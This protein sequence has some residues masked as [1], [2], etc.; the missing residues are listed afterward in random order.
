MDH[1]L[2]T[3][4][5]ERHVGGRSSDAERGAVEAHLEGCAECRQRVADEQLFA[6]VREFYQKPMADDVADDTAADLIELDDGPIDGYRMLHEI[7]RGGQ[8]IVYKAVQIATRRVVAL[9]VVLRGAFATERERRRFEREIDVVASLK[10]SNIVTIFDS[11][12]SRSRHYFAMEYVEGRPL[13]RYL[14]DRPALADGRSSQRRKTTRDRLTMFRHI[15]EAVSHAH[16]RAVIH[17]DLKPANV[18]IDEYGLPHVLDFGLAKFAESN[19][20][21]EQTCFRTHDGDFLGTLAYASPEQAA[22]D[23][24]QIDVRSDVYSLGVMLYELTTDGFPYDVRGELSR[25]LE[26]IR[27]AK[28]RV[29][30]SLEPSID[31][32]LETV[33]LKSLA[34]EPDRRYQ[35]AYHL[36]RDIEHYLT[37]EAIDAK[38]D[39]TWYLLRKSLRRHRAAVGTALA[40]L[41]I[42]TMSLIVSLTLWRQAVLDRDQAVSAGEAAA[43]AQRK[44]E[45]FGREAA[46]KSREADAQRDEAEFQAYAAN[47]AAADGAL[48]R[49]D[50]AEARLR[51]ELAPPAKKDWEWFQ[52]NRQLDTSLRTL[53]GHTSYVENI[54]VA[55]RRGWVVSTSW[56]QTIRIW[57]LADG[58]EIAKIDL[59]SPAW[60]LD[61]NRDETLLAVGDWGHTVHVWDLDSLELAFEVKGPA[62]RVPAVA[63]RPAGKQLA[64]S[65]WAFENDEPESANVVWLIDIPSQDIIRR[66]PQRGRVS[67]LAFTP[68]GSKLVTTDDTGS[69][70]WDVE[71]GERIAELPGRC[72]AA[73]PDGR[74]FVSVSADDTVSVCSF[75]A[76]EPPIPLSGHAGNILNANFSSDSTRV[77]TGGHDKTVRVWDVESGQQIGSHLG[78][79]W[80][81]TAVAFTP[82][83]QRIVSA[84]WD[85]TIK[86][87]DA[88][89]THSVSAI[90]AHSEAVADFALSNDGTRMA[91]ASLD[92][93]IKLWD[94]D[95]RTLIHTFRGHSAPV[96]SVAFSHDATKLA[97][98]SRDKTVKLWDVDNPSPSITM[99]GHTDFVQGVA[100]HPDGSWL[101]SGSRDNTL[102]IWDVADG[103]ELAVLTGH[104]DHVHSVVF[105][106]DAKCFASCGHRS[107]KLWDST[108]HTELHSLRRT[109]I[110]EDYSLAFDPAGRLL[111]AGTDSKAIRFWDLDCMEVI[112]TV[113]GH[114]DEI[115]DICFSPDGAR[116]VSASNDGT[117][118]IWDVE[119]RIPLTTLH[120][121]AGDVTRVSFS[122]DGQFL[123]GGMRDGRVVFWQGR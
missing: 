88:T 60:S 52:L 100:F 34:K 68:D 14:R 21:N 96:Q 39:S 92:K 83:D 27:H 113:P 57:D 66:L 91:T 118:K 59:P 36:A 15:C 9:K 90:N 119:H 10:H 56:D 97:S 75:D 70:L 105:S 63:F 18:M 30:S 22:G 16:Q 62:Q 37:G 77:A 58:R 8:G 65:F 32:E 102:R 1:C 47:I 35:S 42:I 99:E 44:A 89:R 114:S 6:D 50:V 78:H 46:A 122:R 48:R 104:D 84:C 2:E 61:I 109:V 87:W 74:H 108:T 111:V 117:V 101:V 64:A 20:S 110:R 26:N 4:D 12:I 40:F 38:R 11:G 51:L 80:K 31:H 116:M 93:T 13:D 28:P 7:H 120:V 55:R 3:S 71:A 73:A 94:L 23:A 106:P 25:T 41:A 67:H 98:A 121:D 112:D 49:Y 103:N 45:R 85:R 43:T 17:R 86:I 76:S 82:G 81:V 29:P 107:V 69:L 33:I 95:T 19:N 5:V 123:I 54:K 24:T 72:V 115:Y 53:G 79:A